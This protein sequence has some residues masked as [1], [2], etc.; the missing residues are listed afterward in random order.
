M[1][2]MHENRQ[3]LQLP[4]RWSPE[5]ADEKD[6]HRRH[7]YQDFKF[8]NIGNQSERKARIETISF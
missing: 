1:F 5:K 6:H 4:A 7:G 3:D 2:N 8:G